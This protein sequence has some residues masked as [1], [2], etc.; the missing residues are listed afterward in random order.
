MPEKDEMQLLTT[1]DRAFAGALKANREALGLS[2]VQ[3]A[4]QVRR[5]AGFDFITQVTISRIEHL[6]RAPRLGEAHV[7]AAVL[8]VSL[9]SMVVARD[10][11]VLLANELEQAYIAFAEEF[12]GVESRFDAIA[13]N[14]SL[15]GELRA[16]LRTNDGAAPDGLSADE[17]ARIEELVR[18]TQFIEELD[19]RA[20]VRGI[21]KDADGGLQIWRDVE[22]DHGDG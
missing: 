6:K 10:Y 14:A 21:V 15:I 8:G 16:E 12:T 20:G 5:A 22:A 13:K 18:K 9:E 7:L 11:R 1:V 3:L 17:R 2:Q 4:E 19:L